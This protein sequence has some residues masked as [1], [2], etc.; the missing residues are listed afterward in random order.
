MG[1]PLIRRVRLRNY[2]S[3]QSCDVEL[4]NLAFLIGP[5]GAGKS[6]FV[7]ALRFVKEALDVTLEFAVNERSGI[8][9]VRRKGSKT[10]HPTHVG[11]RLDFELPSGVSG[12]YAFDISAKTGGEYAIQKE[13]CSV[14][15]AEGIG[16]PESFTV[17]EGRADWTL[18]AKPPP[19]SADRL[20][21]GPAS[22]YPEF[23]PVFDALTH[24]GF[25]NLNPDAIRRPQHADPGQ[26]L[27]RDGVNI[28]SVL[29][30]LTKAHPDVKR[31]IEDYLGAV[32]P[33]ISG[34]Q[35]V[36]AGPLETLEFHQQAGRTDSAVKFAATSMSDGTLRALA[37][38]VALLQ[39]GNGDG[40]GA[41]LVGI[42]EPELALHPA[43]S[44]VLLDALS[45]A[46]ERVQ[47]IVTSHSTAL[48]DNPEIATETLR[49]VTVDRGRTVIG[50]IDEAG[51]KTLAE[52]LFTPG[53]LLRL[54]QL[55][56]QES[57]YEEAAKQ[58]NLFSSK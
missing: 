30:N 34:V 50:P 1:S 52:Q 56:P 7:D 11:I 5:N 48:L 44:G 21:L 29:A 26:L 41:T 32:V 18:G 24:M 36:P 13:G 8:A 47:V 40:R 23:R 43:A 17:E 6:N 25:Y 51:R 19:V 33:G 55:R 16:S 20:F 46:S 2:K 10:G 45:E 38:L 39:P 3:I 4:G 27:K 37:V 57:A 28:A 35:R 22:G 31:R 15:S 58:L 12:W 49:A 9:E 42:E 54:D 14:F 53:E